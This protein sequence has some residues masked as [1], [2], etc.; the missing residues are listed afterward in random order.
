VARLGDI[1]YIGTYIHTYIGTDRRRYS[2][3]LK[4]GNVWKWLGGGFYTRCGIQQASSRHNGLVAHVRQYQCEKIHTYTYIEVVFRISL[5][6]THS[7]YSNV[8]N[9]E[10]IV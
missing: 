6:C 7:L 8:Y 4:T 5:I 10:K 3:N 1:L 2:I 9:N